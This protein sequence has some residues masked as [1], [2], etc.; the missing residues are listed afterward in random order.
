MILRSV[1]AVVGFLT[2]V[3]PRRIAAFWF[4]RCT[5]NPEDVEIRP[6]VLHAI[7][8]QGLAMLG[9]VLWQSREEFQELMGGASD[10]DD[11]ISFDDD[12]S[13]TEETDEEA[14]T[15][16]GDEDLPTLTPETRRFDMAAILHH[17]DD[18]LTVSEIVDLSDGTEWEIGRSPASATLYRMFNDGVVDRRE[19]EEDG[20]YE[21]WLTEEGEAS[22]G[23]TDAT[24]E[25]NPF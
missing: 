3:A 17:A 4:A 18:P 6:W 20:S 21:Y 2:V 24:I 7:R 19:R 15:T 11:E 25:P 1:L 9:W 10:W 8:L 14:T 13:V 23:R 16:D 22:L 5:T 12:W